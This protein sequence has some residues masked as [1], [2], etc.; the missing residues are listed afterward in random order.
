MEGCDKIQP[1]HPK[2]EERGN[3]GNKALPRQGANRGGD[4]GGGRG[5]ESEQASSTHPKQ[6]LRET[7][8]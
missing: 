8:P 2:S 5:G 4:G 6:I 1:P 3:C 7:N